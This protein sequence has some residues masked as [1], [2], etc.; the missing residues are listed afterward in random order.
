MQAIRYG[1]RGVD[2]DTISIRHG[3]RTAV[4]T[5]KRERP[6]RREFNTE[7]RLV[8]EINRFESM[9]VRLLRRAL[10]VLRIGAGPFPRATLKDGLLTLALLALLACGTGSSS[11][12]PDASVGDGISASSDAPLLGSAVA[13][14]LTHVSKTTQANGDWSSTTAHFALIDGLARGDVFTV[15][16]CGESVVFSPPLPPCTSACPVESGDPAPTDLCTRE[17]SSGQFDSAGKL[18]VDCGSDHDRS[19]PL[20]GSTYSIRFTS[21]QL[22]R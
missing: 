11:S 10:R 2:G 21:I 13:C 17:F 9:P 19:P 5:F 15:E 16:H 4:F 14:N 8:S 3:R 6:G 1:T 18:V 20:I 22:Y 7:K 12:G